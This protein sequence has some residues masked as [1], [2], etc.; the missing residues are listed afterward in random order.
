MK[1]II[2]CLVVGAIVILTS[3]AFGIANVGANNSDSQEPQRVSIVALIASPHQYSGVRVYATGYLDLSYESNAVYFHEED[4]RYGMTKNAIRI[5][6]HRG[7]EQ[8]FK[9]LSRKYVIIEGTFSADDFPS[10]M[11]SGHIVDVTRMQELQTEQEFRRSP[12]E[13]AKP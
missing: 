3:I 10:A 2:R 13:S 9:A 6:L 12:P 7:Q 1:R 4:F 8:Q 5:T 11:F